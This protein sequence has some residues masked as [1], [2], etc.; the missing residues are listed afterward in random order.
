MPEIDPK[1]VATLGAV[2]VD[3]VQ[4]LL[5][6]GQPAGNIAAD[7]VKRIAAQ[8]AQA[9]VEEA[10][11]TLREEGMVLACDALAEA[12]HRLLEELKRLDALMPPPPE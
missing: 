7:D 4:W 5:H 6:H 12:A 8:A 9:A 2:V 10:W 11:A 3:V 1:L